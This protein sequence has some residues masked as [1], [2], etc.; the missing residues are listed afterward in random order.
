MAEQEGIFKDILL[1][2]DIRI[3]AQWTLQTT[4]VE[5]INFEI[6]T[7]LSTVKDTFINTAVKVLRKP[8]K[9][10]ESE[11]KNR[12]VK[13]KKWFSR[14]CN[15]KYKELKMISKSLNRNPNKHFWGLNFTN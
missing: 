1:I 7:L 12:K 13:N 14:A 6:E 11:T 10:K 5:N 3:V 15:D 2:L 8:R 9:H 4:K